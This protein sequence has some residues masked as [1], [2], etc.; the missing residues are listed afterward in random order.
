MEQSSSFYSI[1]SVRDLKTHF[2][3]QEGVLRAVD[4]ISF[5]IKKGQTLSI[6]GES[7]CGK[8]VTALSIIRLIQSPP[9]KIVSGKV[10]FK[11]KDLLTLSE[12]QMRRYRG[13]EIAMV[14]QEPM[15]ALNPVF[16]IGNQIVEVYRIH[17]GLSR[18]EARARSIEVL[19]MVGIP[20]AE[21]R[22]DDYPHELSGGMRQRVLIAMALAC[23]PALLIADE[24][25]TALDVTI[26][27]QIL[28]LLLEL[29]EKLSMTVLLITHD[30]GIVAQNTDAVVV[31][32]A[33]VVVENTSTARLFKRPMHPYTRALH[34][35]LLYNKE[36]DTGERKIHAI[37]GTV[38]DLMNL[39]DECRFANRCELASEECRRGEPELREIEEGHFVRCIKA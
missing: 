6:V 2:Y 16:T 29:K 11:D 39:K 21:K 5:D 9:G 17:H 26:Q 4:G 34:R 35:S 22:I 19:R 25:T 14:F 18:K 12:K 36:G 15:S 37:P 30:L 28:D 27:A 32:Y 7:G 8:S 38:P 20:L 13:K 31:M 23:K 24:P 3:L 1:I 33:G 10:I